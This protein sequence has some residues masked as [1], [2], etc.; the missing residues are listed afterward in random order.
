MCLGLARRCMGFSFLMTDISK[1][2]AGIPMRVKYLQ[3]IWQVSEMYVS[4]LV[5]F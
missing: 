3:S 5:Y 2:D 4:V 1:K